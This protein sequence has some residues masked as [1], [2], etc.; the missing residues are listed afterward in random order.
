MEGELL[1]TISF[2][3]VL[4]DQKFPK[5]RWVSSGRAG[6]ESETSAN[7]GKRLAL[8]PDYASL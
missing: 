2:Q 3:G 7:P 8:R 6:K 5:C 1:E 4:R